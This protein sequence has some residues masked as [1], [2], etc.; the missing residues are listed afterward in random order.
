MS[1]TL[2]LRR[3]GTLKRPFFRIVA[4]DTRNPRDGKFIETVGTYDPKKKS[5][6]CT[7]NKERILHWLKEGAR[8]SETVKN[9]FKRMGIKEA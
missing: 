5:D 9:L 6:D 3:M 2:R 8:P 1:V 7:V 4:T